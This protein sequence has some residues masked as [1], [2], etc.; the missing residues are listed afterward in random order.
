[1]N[2]RDSLARDAIAMLQIRAPV[3]LSPDDSIRTAIERMR[4]EKVGCCVIVEDERPQGIFTEHDVMQRVLA[5][6]IPL[7][8]PVSDV[9]TRPVEVLQ[10]GAPVADV[11]D[12]MYRGGFRHMPVVDRRGKLAG[13]LS[14]KRIVEYIVEHFPASVFNLP[15]HPAPGPAP[16]EGA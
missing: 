15:P 13:I 5:D 11:M 8:A 1:M 6:N 10:E 16:R 7:T 12:V 2:L 4:R 9:M 14:V 3:A